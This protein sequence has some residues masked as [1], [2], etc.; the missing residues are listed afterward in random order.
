MVDIIM[1]LWLDA[2]LY[3]NNNN[4]PLV[5]L[6][7]ICIIHRKEIWRKCGG[8]NC[9]LFPLHFLP[10]SDPQQSFNNNIGNGEETLL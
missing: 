3:L 8:N 6:H 9:T 10:V 4:M 5:P 7:N 1:A 2:R